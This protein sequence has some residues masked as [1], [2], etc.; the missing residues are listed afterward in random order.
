MKA[1]NYGG[2]PRKSSTRHQV[3]VQFLAT[4]L[5]LAACASSPQTDSDSSQDEKPGPYAAQIKAAANDADSQFARD[6]LKDG[7]ITRAEYQEAEDRYLACLR[8][9]GINAA[10]EDQSGYYVLSLPTSDAD[11]PEIETCRR[12][13]TN[14]IEP[15]YHDM[16]TNPDKIDPSENILNCMK[17]KGM[18]LPSGYGAKDFQEDRQRGLANAPFDKDDPAVSACMVNPAF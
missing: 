4:V 15:L 18:K 6:V 2:T 9:A 16:L 11:R 5:V 7:V 8:D 12:G 14:L 17:R 3:V 1:L 13:T 10:L